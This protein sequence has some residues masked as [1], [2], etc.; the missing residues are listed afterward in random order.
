M[1]FLFRN[2][3][4]YSFFI[5]KILFLTSKQSENIKKIILSKKINL[6]FLK[7]DAIQN[8]DKVLT[9]KY[10]HVLQINLKSS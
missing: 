4:K 6:N 7:Y 10:K 2:I 1:C 5:F 8:T 9:I 3:L